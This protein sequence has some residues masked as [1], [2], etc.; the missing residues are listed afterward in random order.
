[1]DT[2]L[3]HIELESTGEVY[4]KMEGGT[5]DIA[6]IITQ[7]MMLDKTLAAIIIAA[8]LSYAD[9]TNTP[10]EMLITSDK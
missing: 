1:M 7:S 8:V 4:L 10:R 9:E 2:A 5:A 6:N 3:F